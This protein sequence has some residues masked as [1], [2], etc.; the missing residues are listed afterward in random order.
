MKSSLLRYRHISRNRK[1]EQGKPAHAARHARHAGLAMVVAILHIPAAWSA[2]Q[3]G[4]E[5]SGEIA[6]LR[7]ALADMRQQYEARINALEARIRRA[8]ISAASA[9]TKATGNEARIEAR[10]APAPVPTAGIQSRAN[11]FNPAISLILQGTGASYSR[12]PEHWRLPGFQSGGEAGLKSEG[13]S[14][15]E[16]ELT[17]SA[18][19][20]NWFYGQVTL[21]LHE[22]AGETEVHVE[23]AFLEN[24]SL[25]GGFG[26]KAGRFFPEIG[27]LNTSHSHTWDFADVSLTG[28]AFLGRQYHDDGLRLSWLAP[29][30]NYL[31]FGVEVL[32]GEKFPASGNSDR[33]LGGAQ[34]WFA[35]VGGDIGAN[36]SFL[37][38]LS[39]LRAEPE[40]RSSGHTHE[41]HA[42]ETFAF[43]GDSDLTVASLVWKWAPGGNAANRSL[44]LQGEYFHRDE[45]GNVDFEN[46]ASTALL[47]YDGAQQG[48]YLQGVYRFLPNWR[49]GIRH[50]RLWSDNDL[51]VARKSAGLDNNEL[52]EESGLLGRHDP[53]RW[54]LMSD[55]SNSEFSRLRFQYAK[56]YSVS[57][58]G[59][60]QFL[61]QYIMSLGSHG[62]HS[63]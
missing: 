44:T 37:A 62:A 33:L 58:D 11:A 2:E 23:E 3:S 46:G 13:L 40:K 49:A 36:H 32:R 9:E 29:T 24:L 39:H 34:N 28:Q 1:T 45:E 30:E 16:T 41:D 38:G 7:R 14:L 5:G 31:E 8:E 52:L 55:Y 54:T 4:A 43:S 51:G 22:H 59:D 19:V 25:P 6:E 15:D 48:A 27:Y 56:D 53:Y 42:G 57:D 63:Y 10:A 61:I 35:R 26:L 20:D 60:D 50:D 21:G 12:N 17:A 47:P 18:N